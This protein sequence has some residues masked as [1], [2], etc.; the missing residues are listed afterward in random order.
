MHKMYILFKMSDDS[1]KTSEPTCVLCNEECPSPPKSLQCN[2]FVY[3]ELCV[4]DLFIS[5]PIVNTTPMRADSIHGSEG[6]TK[7]ELKHHHGMDMK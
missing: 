6:S 5:N 1:K 4:D 3:C 7:K 2:G